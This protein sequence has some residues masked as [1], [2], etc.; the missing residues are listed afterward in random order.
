M[1]AQEGAKQ[2][3]VLGHLEVQKFVDDGFGSESGGLPQQTRGSCTG[4]RRITVMEL[5]FLLEFP[6]GKSIRRPMGS[7]AG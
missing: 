4:G 5:P 7:E 3:P 1:A 2:P 6:I